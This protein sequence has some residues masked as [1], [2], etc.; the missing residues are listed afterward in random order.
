MSTGGG[1]AELASSRSGVALQPFHELQINEPKRLPGIPKSQ[2]D[3]GL[4]I[5]LIVKDA[6]RSPNLSARASDPI[7]SKWTRTSQADQAA[8]PS[9]CRRVH[10][11]GGMG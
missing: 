6:L 1:A 8:L 11:V 2:C 3:V 7:V 4:L 5:M 10:N 9:A